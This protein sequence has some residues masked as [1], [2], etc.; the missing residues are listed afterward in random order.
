[1]CIYCIS[2][3]STAQMLWTLSATAFDYMADK[4]RSIKECKE[5]KISERKFELEETNVKTVIYGRDKDKY[6][7][8]N[9]YKMLKI[10]TL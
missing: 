1:M 2:V 10:V 7:S 5:A 3:H 9:N 4:K 6:M 8:K